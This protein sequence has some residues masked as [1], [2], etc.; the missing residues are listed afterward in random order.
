MS[1][2]QKKMVLWVIVAAVVSL[3]LLFLYFVFG[4]GEKTAE[5]VQSGITREPEET[6]SPAP[7]SDPHKGMVRSRFTGQWIDKSV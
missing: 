4:R 5:P 7:T 2:G 6:A 3:G 1:S